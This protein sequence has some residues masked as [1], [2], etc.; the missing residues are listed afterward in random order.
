[1]KL[2]LLCASL[3]VLL[4][5]A[6]AR[7][8][9]TIN[10]SLLL[11][12]TSLDYAKTDWKYLLVNFD[13]ACKWCLIFRP[14][15]KQARLDLKAENAGVAFGWLNLKTNPQSQAKYN[16]TNHPTQL[17]F[18]KGYSK[19]PLKYTGTKNT[20]GLKTWVK[21]KLAQVKALGY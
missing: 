7:V 14:Y 6:D 15:Y 13:K 17:L 12:D 18:V 9:S 16:I 5:F 20:N 4:S 3:A 19:S 1:M 8:Y 21:A 10:G 11:N 2:L